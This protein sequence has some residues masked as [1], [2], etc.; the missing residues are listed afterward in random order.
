MVATN[1]N[2]KVFNDGIIKAKKMID[3]RIINGL[4]NAA[5]D[6][7]LDAEFEKEYNNLTG[8]T[9]TSYAVGIYSKMR[10]RAL[11]SIYDVD[12]GIDRP[13]R[14]KLSNRKG[15]QK[16]IHY[17][18]GDEIYVKTD[19]FEKTSGEY[20]HDTSEEF[21]R[22]FIPDNMGY[23]LVMCTGTEYSG[24]LEYGGLNVLTDTFMKSPKIFFS[25]LKR[26]KI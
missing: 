25:N 4:V 26:M 17:D 18:T 1:R 2:S 10:L 16:V 5:K 3:D 8:N 9:L 21:L 19:S 24:I 20:G 15:Y 7:I 22:Q 23:F 14:I 11:I 6:L 13:T 12:S